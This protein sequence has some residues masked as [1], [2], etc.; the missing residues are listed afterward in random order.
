M[1]IEDYLLVIIPIGLGLW[2]ISLLISLT[3]IL[4]G[5]KESLNW[6]MVTGK[7]IQSRVLTQRTHE[8]GSVQGHLLQYEYEVGGIKYTSDKKIYGKKL[9]NTGFKSSAEK[10]VLK[11]PVGLDVDVFHHPIDHSTALL[12]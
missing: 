11:Y 5:A 4:K 6:P 1:A 2:G 7:V 9:F 10:Q 8:G 12:T 3:K